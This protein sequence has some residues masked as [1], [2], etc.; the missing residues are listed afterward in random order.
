MYRVHNV[1]GFDCQESKELMLASLALPF[2][3]PQPPYSREGK[4]RAAFIKC[5]PMRDLRPRVCPLTERGCRYKTAPFSL[6]PS[7]PIGRFQV[8]HVSDGHGAKGRESPPHQCQYARTIA[9]LADN[10]RHRI[11]KD[12][13]QAWKV[14]GLVTHHANGLLAARDAVKVAHFGR[15][16]GQSWPGYNRAIRD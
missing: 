1:I 8:A 6:E 9:G 16:A 4:K 3:C 12:T 11:G 5:K 15:T 14:A 13:R 10:R 2:A 7:A